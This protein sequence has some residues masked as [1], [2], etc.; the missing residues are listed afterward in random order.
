MHFSWFMYLFVLVL[1]SLFL[2]AKTDYDSDNDIDEDEPESTTRMPISSTTTE[3]LELDEA[4]E[5]HE[6]HTVKLETTGPTT[7][8]T[9]AWNVAKHHESDDYVH[10]IY[11]DVEDE[12]GEEKFRHTTPVITKL[13][14][15]SSTTTST[16][17]AITE[18]ATTKNEISVTHS[19]EPFSTSVYDSNEQSLST[20]TI[21]FKQM[22]AYLAQTSRD[23]FFLKIFTIIV[24]V[25]MFSLAVAFIIIYMVRKARRYHGYNTSANG[26]VNK[27]LKHP[28][29]IPV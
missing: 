6:D 26:S 23:R 29:N 1:L 14:S 9:N 4:I 15:S 2:P 7:T 20:T 27:Q 5:D 18:T 25:G 24:V 13:S 28:N 22:A 16:K 11:D 10:N 3:S 21:D 17:H 19:T 8:T 12:S